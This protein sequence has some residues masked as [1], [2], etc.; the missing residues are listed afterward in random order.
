MWIFKKY[1]WKD[2]LTHRYGVSKQIFK[3]TFF[4]KNV[5]FLRNVI[6]LRKYL[7]GQSQPQTWIFKKISRRAFQ[8]LNLNSWKISGGIFADPNVEFWEIFWKDIQSFKRRFFKK[9]AP[10]PKYGF[11]K[12]ICRR[13]FPAR[14]VD[15]KK[16]I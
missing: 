4:A 5:D 8:A 9:K 2:F 13:T 7:K 16:K 15:L 11:F 3:R 6:F 10:S 12:K 1:F 14:N